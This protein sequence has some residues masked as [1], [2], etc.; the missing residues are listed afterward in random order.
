MPGVKRTFS[1][2]FPA[3]LS[4]GAGAGGSVAGG[5]RPYRGVRSRPKY[6][7]AAKVSKSVKAYVK[8]AIQRD[9]EIK[10]QLDPKSCQIN[11][12]IQGPITSTTAV[13][14][15]TPLIPQLFTG[16][17]QGERLG[18]VVKPKSLEVRGA[19]TMNGSAAQAW[20]VRVRMMIVTDRSNLD[21]G[22]A[23]QFANVVGSQLLYAQGG[24]GATVGYTGK[25][26]T[27]WLPINTDR[28]QVHYDREFP[29]SM[30]TGTTS[31]FS[32]LVAGTM[33][34]MPINFTQPFDIKVKLPATLKYD[35]AASGPWPTN[36]APYLLV[37]FCMPDQDYV[38]SSMG[39]PPVYYTFNSKLTYTDA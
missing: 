29:L 39:P 38:A 7:K 12:Y 2:A 35:D 23:A 3:T 15:I 10:V 37:G 5:G 14:N 27:H 17:T 18:S 13:T 19:I 26:S 24:A 4:I 33:T 32:P 1:N 20:A 6:R 16:V 11:Q 22:Q 25:V 34:S 36:A 8:K 31:Q 28:Y 9:E 21:Q 30:P